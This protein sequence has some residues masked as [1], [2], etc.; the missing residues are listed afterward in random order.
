MLPT[1]VRLRDPAL[2]TDQRTLDRYF[3]TSA[4]QPAP[5]YSIGND[6]RTHMTRWGRC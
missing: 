1:A 4:F 6:S 3:E 5:T 2:P